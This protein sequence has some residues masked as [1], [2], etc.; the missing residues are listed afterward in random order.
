MGAYVPHPEGL[1]AIFP[2]LLSDINQNWEDPHTSVDLSNKR[3][4]FNSVQKLSE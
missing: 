3:F 4:P 2:S 1:N